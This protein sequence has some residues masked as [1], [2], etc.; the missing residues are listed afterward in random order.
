[1]A[2]KPKLDL[3]L[4]SVMKK[5]YGNKYSRE[6]I[7]RNGIAQNDV[8]DNHE[9][10]VDFR[11]N[12]IKFDRLG[13]D[14]PGPSRSDVKQSKKSKY[15]SEQHSE[16][17]D[18]GNSK[19]MKKL[20]QN[21][22][23]KH[24]KNV[25]TQLQQPQTIKPTLEYDIDDDIPTSVKSNKSYD[26][27]EYYEI[28]MDKDSLNEESKEE[29]VVIRNIRRIPEYDIDEDPIYRSNSRNITRVEIKTD[30]NENSASQRS[31]LDQNHI[32]IK[33]VP[34]Y[35]IE[36]DTKIVLNLTKEKTAYN[37]KDQEHTDVLHYKTNDN[38]NS[39]TGSLVYE[40]DVAENYPQ[41]RY[42]YQ[43]YNE[44]YIRND[45]DNDVEYLEVTSETDAHDF[46]MKTTKKYAREWY[47]DE[48]SIKSN[49]VLRRESDNNVQIVNT[50]LKHDAR[51]FENYHQEE[52]RIDARHNP[53]N[54]KE[55]KLKIYPIDYA[56]DDQGYHGSNEQSYN[57]QYETKIIEV[58]SEDNFNGTYNGMLKKDRQR[59]LPNIIK[60]V[61]FKTPSGPSS[62][63]SDSFSSRNSSGSENIFDAWEMVQECER[64]LKIKEARDLEQEE[65]DVVHEIQPSPVSRMQPPIPS[66]R[67]SIQS[68]VDKVLGNSET[69][70]KYKAVVRE[71]KKSC[72]FSETDA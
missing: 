34:E 62:Y 26:D 22:K 17:L 69:T 65:G 10:V 12:Q 61:T 19:P 41:N 60:T 40:H 68:K 31:S 45:T 72:S 39:F 67:L 46:E 38:R 57:E 6:N 43:W 2:R 71:L 28:K 42:N 18:E 23:R 29:E 24:S 32:T 11:E 52:E 33:T 5:M 25:T 14:M 48:E 1:M 36:E 27:P 44:K 35:D 9:P 50:L 51:P 59:Q 4:P 53:L 16:G 47:E 37:S 63:T 56:D 70:T 15:K 54:I 64:N 8:N 7:I 20:M 58:N 30:D 55:L 13:D 3:H 49:D 66:P 21:F